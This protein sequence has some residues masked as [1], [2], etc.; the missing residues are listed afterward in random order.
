MKE[1]VVTE[2]MVVGKKKINVRK[3]DT[4]LVTDPERDR[5][6]TE[7]IVASNKTDAQFNVRQ[8]K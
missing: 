7:L 4:K 1:R 5:H 6:S 3:H 8:T 2:M